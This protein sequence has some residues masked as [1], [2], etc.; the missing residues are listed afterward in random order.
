MSTQLATPED[1]AFFDFL[2]PYRWPNASKE[3]IA[4]YR[5]LVATG[6]IQ[7][8]T[9]L[10]NALVQ[11]SNGLYT[12]VAEDHADFTDGSDAKKAVSNFR[13]NNIWRDLWMNTW[14]ISNTKNKTGM[15]RVVC[16]SKQTKKFHFFAIPNHA[17]KNISFLEIIL[18]RSSGY[19]EP[20]GIP[21]GKWV[22]K[23]YEVV[24]FPTLA[25]I[26]T[27][28]QE[29]VPCLRIQKFLINQGYTPDQHGYALYHE[30]LERKNNHCYSD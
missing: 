9:L 24:D 16:Y 29:N 5:E 1:F 23:G 3:K 2:A 7:I 10:E 27:E 13:C 26:R 4:I 28:D 21:Q 14:R 11:T 20:K 15:L 22:N 18:D 6:E 25:R 8:E 30:N 17:Y 12:R 19:R